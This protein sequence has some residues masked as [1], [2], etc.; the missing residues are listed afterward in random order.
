MPI[1]VAAAQVALGKGSYRKALDDALRLIRQAAAFG[2]QLVCL[3]EHWLLEYREQ[4][5]GALKEISEL[6]RSERI[7]I[8]AGA[9]YT[10]VQTNSSSEVRI[11]SFLVGPD[12]NALGRQ[13][14]VHLFD[15]EKQVATPGE[16]YEV[17][18][19]PLGKIGITMT[20]I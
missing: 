19:S 20:D 10:Q 6:A 4:G 5:Y 3:P 18:D 11:C 2:A 1:R 14:K 7:Y 15:G 13:D 17:F 8:V 12:G 16:G 9:N